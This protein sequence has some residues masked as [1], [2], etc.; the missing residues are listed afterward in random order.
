MVPMVT[1]RMA[2]EPAIL[3]EAADTI[4]S[5]VANAFQERS[6]WIPRIKEDVR[7]ATTQAMAGIPESC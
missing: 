6:R 2:I 4:P 7:R 5:V 3:F 1:E